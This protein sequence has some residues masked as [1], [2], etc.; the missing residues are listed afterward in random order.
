MKRDFLWII[1]ALFLLC[2]CVLL[3]VSTFVGVFAIVMVVVLF[4]FILSDEPNEEEKKKIAE[5]KVHAME[6]RLKEENRKKIE[7]KQLEETLRKMRE[8]KQW[9]QKEYDEMTNKYPHGI[10]AF[11]KN[12]P[13]CT[14]ADIIDKRAEVWYLE[15]EYKNEEMKRIE[16]ERLKEKQK[17]EKRDYDDLKK[18]YPHGVEAFEKSHPS[19]S[20]A[21]IIDKRTDVWHLEQDYKNEEKKRIEEEE[22]KK[23]SKESALDSRLEHSLQRFEKLE[24]RR[25]FVLERLKLLKE[26]GEYFRNI[27]KEWERLN[28]VFIYSW[29]FYYYPTT[30]DFDVKGRDD[31]NR[32]TVWNFKNDS[33]RNIRYYAHERALDTVLP[34][35]RN[36]LIL[37]YG[38]KNL[39]EL[40]LVCIPAST[41]V[42]NKARYESFSRKLCEK[43][44]MENGYEHVHIVKD[45][46]SKN[47]PNNSSGNSIRPEVVF[48]EWFDGKFV[49]LFDDV[50][51]K[52]DTMLYYKQQLQKVDAIVVGGICLGKTRHTQQTTTEI[53]D[54]LIEQKNL[55]EEEERQAHLETEEYLQALIKKCQRDGLNV[56]N[57]SFQEEEDYGTGA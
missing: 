56:H 55:R 26:A 45:G 35:L 34:R 40:T 3:V 4:F 19:C 25:P 18:Y 11:E 52:G 13:G 21:E 14:Y 23:N 44:G 54:N 20:Y 32:K 5:A 9:E 47:D 27:S 24:K 16:E 37:L 42:K 31:E 2:A 49:V 17:I 43:T 38:R 28:G 36:R 41:Q 50:V 10:A 53:L 57:N 48:D 22:R 8:K 29:L 7:E 51:T 46:I 39:K 6:N 1:F 30:C 12:H 15:Q 33:S